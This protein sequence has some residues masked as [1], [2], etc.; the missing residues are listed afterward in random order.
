MRT[1][2]LRENR[3]SHV[4]LVDD[5]PVTIRILDVVLRKAGYDVTTVST[6]ADVHT[7][8]G[9]DIVVAA[10][11][12]SPLNSDRAVQAPPTT[13]ALVVIT[14]T[15]RGDVASSIR[16]ATFNVFDESGQRDG[17][18][19]A[20]SR[21]LARS[22]VEH[23]CSV[24]AS[25]EHRIAHAAARWARLVV[26]VTESSRDTPTIDAWGRFVAASPGAVRNWCRTAGVPARRS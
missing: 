2:L 21:A 12:Q 6:A 5:N 24:D 23:A 13:L 9:F 1:G 18:V 15:G 7:A 3:M 17:L 14:D 4:L 26:R 16:G 8:D 19:G 11:P 25:D 10:S 22:A 20:V